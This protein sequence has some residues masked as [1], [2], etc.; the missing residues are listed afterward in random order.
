MTTFLRLFDTKLQQWKVDGFAPFLNDYLQ[1]WKHQDQIVE[2][3]GMKNK[4]K[5]IGLDQ[6]SWF[7]QGITLDENNEILTLHPDGNSFDA[8]HGLISPKIY[9]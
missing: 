1:H 9:N 3:S 4:V 7:L 2:V 8:L 5:I 6:E